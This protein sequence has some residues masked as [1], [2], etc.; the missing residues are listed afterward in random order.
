MDLGPC[1]D[2]PLLSEGE[3]PTDTLD[4]ICREDRYATLVVSVEMRPVVRIARLDEHPDDDS[5]KSADLGHHPILVRL[6]GHLKSEL[7]FSYIINP[8]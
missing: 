1:D 4:G 3:A 2:Q 8:S 5:E 7:R 6:V